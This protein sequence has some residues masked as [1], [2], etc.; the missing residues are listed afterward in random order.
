MFVADDDYKLSTCPNN[1]GLC[2]QSEYT[3]DSDNDLKDI[4]LTGM[5]KGDVCNYKITVKNSKNRV[6]TFGIQNLTEN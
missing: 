1:E 6:P 2:G 3:M 5:K 4:E